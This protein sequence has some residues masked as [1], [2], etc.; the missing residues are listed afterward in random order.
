MYCIYIT[1]V[2]IKQDYKHLNDVTLLWLK[3]IQQPD[4]YS[5]NTIASNPESLKR[6]TEDYY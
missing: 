2:N 6:M 3:Y 4:S 5:V 1:S